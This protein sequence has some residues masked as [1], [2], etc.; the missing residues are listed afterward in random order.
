MH[1]DNDRIRYFRLARHA[2]LAGLNILGCRPGEA[3]LVPAF[4]CRDL[5]A[6]IHAMGLVPVFY[7]VNSDMS[8]VILPDVD[9]VCAILA[10]NYFGFPQDL[11]L[12]REYCVRH[13]VALIED[14]AHGYLSRDENGELL[15]ARGDF[16]LFSLRKTFALPDGAMLMVNRPEWQSRLSLQ[17]PCRREPLGSAYWIKKGLAWLQRRTGMAL[18]AMG[19]DVI[20]G[21]RF[22][23]TGHAI[24]PLPP[25]SEFEMPPEFAPHCH[26]MEALS[27]LDQVGE[28]AR[29]R[30]LY[31]EFQTLFQSLNVRPVF[32]GLPAGMVPYGYPFYADIQ[33][34]QAA[35]KLARRRG[36]DCIPWPDL[37]AA[38]AP[39]APV[40]YKS[41][42]MVNFI[43]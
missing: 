16:G 15:G 4:V 23:R 37:P 8:P 36:F 27:K 14:N 26:T 29:R 11:S 32:G 28:I 34:A 30:R 20:R 43:C 24:A 22:W 19:Q 40:H 42:W 31:G 41:L 35:T 3:V 7:D 25:E 39:K 12:F 9:G 10:V 17:L 2:F 6:P 38:V 18:L 13:R 1:P 21:F 5:L 33:T